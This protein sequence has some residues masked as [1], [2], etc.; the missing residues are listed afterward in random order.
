MSPP[1]RPNSVTARSNSGRGVGVLRRQ[2]RETAEPVRISAHGIG[3]LVVG[4]TGE[5]D[6]ARDVGLFLDTRVEQRQDLEVDS[7]GVHLLES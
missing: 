3:E 5:V 2:C 6:R 7:C 4:A 1:T